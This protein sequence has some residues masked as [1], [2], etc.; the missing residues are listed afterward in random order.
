MINQTNGSDVFTNY[1]CN[2]D[3]ELVKGIVIQGMEIPKLAIK[4]S[5]T[6]ITEYSNGN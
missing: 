5:Q 4:I 2:K 6:F 1:Q 3:L